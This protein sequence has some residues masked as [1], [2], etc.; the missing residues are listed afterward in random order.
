M[1]GRVSCDLAPLAGTQRT[2]QNRHLLAQISSYLTM[3]WHDACKWQTRNVSVS[4]TSAE[5][6]TMA[7][8]F[9]L[10]EPE[11][12]DNATEVISS[13][14]RHSKLRTATATQTLLPSRMR[15]TC[16]LLLSSASFQTRPAIAQKC[17]NMHMC[18]RQQRTTATSLQHDTGHSIV[19]SDTMCRQLRVC[20][21]PQTTS[22]HTSAATG[23]VDVS[24]QSHPAT[25]CLLEVIQVQT[26]S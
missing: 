6:V 25:A 4:Y 12:L 21:R 11:G 24:V 23:A 20:C 5:T 13:S 2:T 17:V 1:H 8:Q 14:W 19:Q 18:V 9:W 16:Q 3:P 22:R 7:K 15:H 10:S 26:R